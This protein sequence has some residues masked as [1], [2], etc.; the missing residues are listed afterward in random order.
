VLL[1]RG[2]LAALVRDMEGD[3]SL[4]MATGGQG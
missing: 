3:S 4:F 2:L 1:H